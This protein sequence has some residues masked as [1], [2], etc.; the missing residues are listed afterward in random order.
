MD[1]VPDHLDPSNKKDIQES[2]A[3]LLLQRVSS[4]VETVLCQSGARLFCPAAFT[5]LQQAD[6][7]LLDHQQACPLVSAQIHCF[8]QSLRTPNVN[9]AFACLSLLQIHKT[10]QLL[11]GLLSC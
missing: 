9:A 1:A 4:V 10:S 2:G 8:L 11:H 3:G 7:S 6:T 5:G